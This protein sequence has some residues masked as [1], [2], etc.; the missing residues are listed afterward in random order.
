[1]TLNQ[2]VKDARKIQAIDA[3]WDEWIGSEFYALGTEDERHQFILG[4]VENRRSVEFGDEEN[5]SDP[6][7]RA[8]RKAIANFQRKYG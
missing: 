3:E 4:E 7:L 8:E 2:L 1:M 5:S 6:E